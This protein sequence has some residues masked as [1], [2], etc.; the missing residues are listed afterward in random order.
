MAEAEHREEKPTIAPMEALLQACSRNAPLEIVQADRAGEEPFARGRMLE[1]EDG[2]LMVEQV[3]MIGKVAKF[4]KKTPL[5][6]YFRFG[7]RLYEF[8]SRVV[9]VDEAVKL[10]RALL[11]PAMG[12]ELPKAVEEG[13]RRNVYRIP[14][15][16]LKDPIRVEVW[17][18]MEVPDDSELPLQR[19]QTLDGDGVTCSREGGESD[20]GEVLVPSR[21]ADWGGT[22]VDASDVGLGVNIEKCRMT[23][24]KLFSEFW[25]RFS[26]PG[27]DEGALAFKAEVRQIRSVREG[28]IRVGLLVLEGNN[29][30]AHAGKVRRL[31]GFLTTWRRRVCR[32]IDPTEMGK[33]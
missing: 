19:G 27:D 29:R 16:A 5:L 9:T 32:V 23:E 10:N 1:I 20:E 31:W 28:V 22:L 25:V 11:V 18:E 2:V 3:Q 14:L 33:A 6:A 15:S 24:I 13:Q 4:A 12:I 30:W 8:R 17:R 21:R 7:H 26:I